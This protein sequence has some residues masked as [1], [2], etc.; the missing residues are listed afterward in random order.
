MALSSDVLGTQK[1]STAALSEADRDAL[2]A[3]AIVLALVLGTLTLARAL[4][5]SLAPA[6]SATQATLNLTVPGVSGLIQIAALLLL[7]RAFA[8]RTVKETLSLR[9]PP[10]RFW[11]WG[12]L[13][14]GLFVVKFGAGIAMSWGAMQLGIP[15]TPKEALKPIADL[16]RQAGWPLLLAGGIIAAIAEELLF[17]GYLSRRLEATRLG[18]MGGAVLTSLIWAGLHV[19]FPLSTQ[20]LL[21]VTGIALSYVR[22]HTGS[23]YPGMIWHV[24]NNVVALLAVR[25]LVP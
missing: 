11:H 12:A 10:L 17:R 13:I 23:V 3:L 9:W 6:A 24:L 19:G 14:V 20:G 22:A 2:T 4:L 25:A 1:P 5:A 7:V 15:P 18:L 16:M 8:P 21:F